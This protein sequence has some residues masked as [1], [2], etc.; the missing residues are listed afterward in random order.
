[1]RGVRQAGRPHAPGGETQIAIQQAGDGKGDKEQRHE[2]QAVGVRMVVGR[3]E[4]DG[5]V[6]QTVEQS[7]ERHPAF[8]AEARR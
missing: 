3:Q 1:M 4:N 7:G 6:K 2:N 5:H 8:V